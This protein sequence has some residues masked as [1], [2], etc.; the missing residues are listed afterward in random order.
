MGSYTTM[1]INATLENNKEVRTLAMCLGKD[2]CHEDTDI[3]DED[4]V[5]ALQRMDPY[6][7]YP[8]FNLREHELLFEILSDDRFSVLGSTINTPE[9]PSELNVVYLDD[10][11]TIKLTAGINQRSFSLHE[12]ILEFIQKHDVGESSKMLVRYEHD[13]YC[14]DFD[15]N[16]MDAGP[17]GTLHYMKEG[18]W[19][20]ETVSFVKVLESAFEVDYVG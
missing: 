11:I 2:I 13:G 8:N 17:C 6:M 7:I 18:E 4:A 9:I 5:V 14:D 16:N 20:D 19:Y 1:A 15:A 3:I 12:K 10:V